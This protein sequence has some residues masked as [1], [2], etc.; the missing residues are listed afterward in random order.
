MLISKIRL[1]SKFR[2]AL[3]LSE[4]EI[5]VEVLS[6]KWWGC[7]LAYHIA[8]TTNSLHYPDLN[9][10]GKLLMELRSEILNNPSL[11]PKLKVIKARH[12]IDATQARRRNVKKWV[13]G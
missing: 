10:L 5:L 4:D 3:L 9:K 1:I 11:Y 7:G 6:D 8:F 2:D 13:L 12:A